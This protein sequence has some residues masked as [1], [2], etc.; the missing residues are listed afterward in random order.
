[1]NIFA[2]ND[3]GV[4]ISTDGGASWNSFSDGLPDAVLV[5]DVT[6]SASNR[7]LRVATHGNGIFERKL[8]DSFP[9]V[10]LIAP[11][12]GEAWEG[13]ST[14]TIQ[15]T[16]LLTGTLKLEYSLDD[17]TNW[18]TIVDNLPPSPSS[19]AWDVPFEVTTTARVGV[20]STSNSLI[21][22]VSD[23]AFTLYFNGAGLST[24]A[25]WD[26]ISL[27]VRAYTPEVSSLFTNAISYAFGF[28]GSYVQQSSLSVGNGYWLKFGT[29]ETI[30]IKGDTLVMDT[31]ALVEGWNLVGSL[32]APVSVASVTSQ[33]E[34]IF[35]SEFFGYSRGYEIASTIEPGK[36]YWIKTNA[37]GQM[38][39]SSSVAPPKRNTFATLEQHW[40][41]LTLN[42]KD[43]SAQTLY[44]G[45]QIQAIEQRKLEL[46]PPPPSGIFDARFSS[47]RMLEVVRQENAVNKFPISI[48]SATFPL[49]VSWEVFADNTGW[50]LVTNKKTVP[51]NG[52]GSLVLS[53]TTEAESIVL[54]YD[55]SQT[56]LPLQ[57][58]LLQNYPNPFNPVTVIGYQLSANSYVTMKVYDV[59]GREVVTL[60]DEFQAAGF[61]SQVFDASV[62]P[63][64][65]YVYK[66]TADNVVE[67]RKMLLVK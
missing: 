12:G 19:Y 38:I 18:T 10:S 56:N 28:N 25:G 47:H 39:I 44:F 51:I 36:G 57:T 67:S 42:D 34:N 37:G 22:D 2:G 46:P 5:S 30:P 4:Y 65:I 3:I 58:R 55:E 61:K 7:T 64:G 60:V 50:L 17:G 1:N 49:T 41:R 45:K 53:N 54:A 16:P 15:W 24:T 11:N 14:Q 26:I 9:A 32:T 40:N 35:E 13:V 6:Y 29:S 43:G 21:S 23:S 27:P 48:H 63:S 31:V 20:S 62:L 33:P 59:Q 66:L 8:P 52:S